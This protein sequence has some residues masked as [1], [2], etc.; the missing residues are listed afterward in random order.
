MFSECRKAPTVSII[1]ATK[2]RDEALRTISLP[3]LLNQD[4]GDFEVVLWDASDSS[5]S[6]DVACDFEDMFA[7]R[8]ISLRCFAAPRS[9][10]V[11]QR[12]DAVREA[13]GKLLFFIDDDSEMSSDGVSGLKECFT[14]YSQSMGGALRVE[15]ASDEAGGGRRQRWKDVFY[16]MIGHTRKRKVA[17]SGS[18]KG[19]GAPP[20]EAEWLSGCSMAF[21]REVF[22]DLRFN[23]K[24]ETFGPYALAED[25]EF[26]HRVYKHYG[27]P[28]MVAEKGRVV[29][30]AVS[31]ER[32][33]GTDAKAAMVFYNRYLVMLAASQRR[34]LAGHLVF[35]WTALRI[36]VKLSRS[37][38]VR[39]ALRGLR[40]AVRQVLKDRKSI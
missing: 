29:H 8:G 15:D 40:M 14:E 38:G 6:R 4:D 18:A 20:G 7:V 11:S 36:L 39:T 17:L 25:I 19:L 1:I 2:N 32:V 9:G 33:A 16:K 12:N 26:S 5:R 13:T 23:E 35:A 24:L 37:F 10:L 21:R 28:L 34:R 31:G 30:H 3:S 22:N 27:R